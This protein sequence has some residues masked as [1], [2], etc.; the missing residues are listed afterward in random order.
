MPQT[1]ILKSKVQELMNRQWDLPA[2]KSR[3][4]KLSKDNILKKPLDPQKIVSEKKQILDR[5]QKRAEEYEYLSHS[6]SKGSALAVMEEFGL[7]NMEIIKAMSPFPGF[8]MTGWICGGIIGSLVALGLF[9][10]S[11]DLLDYESTGRTMTAA[12][13]FIPRFEQEVGTVL[14]PKIHEDVVFGKYIN[15]RES[16]ENFDAFI[17]AKG[18]ERCALLPGIGARIAAEI[19]IES[20]VEKQP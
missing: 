19:I 4:L 5:V 12:R 1:E 18:Y 8:G 11:D 15:A 7:G 9:F 14:C 10:G 20:L 17:A 13:T 3:Y 2:I 16:K 6:C